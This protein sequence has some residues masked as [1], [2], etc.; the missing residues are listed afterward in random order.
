MQNLPDVLKKEVGGYLKP[1]TPFTLIKKILTVTYHILMENADA[2]YRVI[3]IYVNPGI[4]L[5]LYVRYSDPD[6][7]LLKELNCS[8]FI[9]DAAEKLEC[10]VSF[11]FNFNT[12]REKDKAFREVLY[13]LRYILLNY[14]IH[15]IDPHGDLY[16]DLLQERYQ[17]IAHKQLDS[18][19]LSKMI[20]EYETSIKVKRG[21]QTLNI[22]RPLKHPFY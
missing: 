10:E 8:L 5:S 19:H 9:F 13:F 15:K 17:T 6:H 18:L 4:Q 7:N 11:N 2:V 20:D 22:F 16:V 3:D 14:K 1:K 12:K 21:I